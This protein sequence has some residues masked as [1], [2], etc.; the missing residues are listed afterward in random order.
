MTVVK[1]ILQ[2]WWNKRENQNNKQNY[3]SFLNATDNVANVATD[4]E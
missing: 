1:S 4:S 3:V 2:S